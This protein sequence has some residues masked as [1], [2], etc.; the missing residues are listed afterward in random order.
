MQLCLCRDGESEY[1]QSVDVQVSASR[2]FCVLIIAVL[3]EAFA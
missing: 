3:A 1:I 2:C